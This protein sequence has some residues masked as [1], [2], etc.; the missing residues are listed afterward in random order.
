[1]SKSIRDKDI[2]LGMAV[3]VFIALVYISMILHT[4]VSIYTTAGHDDAWFI[5]SAEKILSA[6]WL[7][8]FSQITLMKG[9]GFSYFLVINNI[10]GFPV[11]L[12]IS[13]LYILACATL[14]YMLRKTGQGKLMGQV[15]F[16]VLLLQP[17]L[18]PMRII[19]D[20][21]YYSLTLMVISGM[22]YLAVTPSS[23]VKKKLLAF[24]GLTAGL[25]W[26]TREEGIWI[27]PGVI[28]I[29][30][31]GLLFTIKQ[32]SGM[33]AYTKHTVYYVLMALLIP[34]GT[35]V[36]NYF[37]YGAFEIVDFK[38]KSFVTAI[39][40][41]NS[42]KA[43]KE[44]PFVPVSYE[45]RIAIY[46]VSPAFRELKPYFEK[47]GKHWTEPGTRIY[48]HVHDDYASGWFMWALRDGVASRGYYKDPNS[49]RQYYS[50]LVKE[51]NQ[52]CLDGRLTCK[53]PLL[54]FMPNL[55]GNAIQSIP[56]KMVDA[57]KLTLYQ[58]DLPL[59]AGLSW[60]P[61]N[62]LTNVLNFLGN[63]RIIPP[64]RKV[65]VSG[66]YY[67]R[68]ESWISLVIVKPK[69]EEK[70]DLKRLRS[71]DIASSFK[72]PQA[73]HQ[74]YEFEVDNSDDIQV[75]L[76]CNNDNL[77]T[78]DEIELKPP[79]F[80]KVGNGLLHVDSVD[81]PD[82]RLEKHPAFV[83]KKAL[84][85]FFRYLS[86]ALFILGLI[87]LAVLTVITIKGKNGYPTLLAISLAFWSLY[88]SR[89]I[90]VVL[91][92]ITSF[93][94]INELYLLPAFPLWIVASFTSI[95]G[96]VNI[97]KKKHLQTYNAKEPKV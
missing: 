68:D 7:G 74:R 89:L 51:I 81:S 76:V 31:F 69:S 40:A 45:K 70:I 1:M 58:K 60:L 86:P 79:K 12:S 25:F 95:A 56:M 96:V 48:P 88:F 19:R 90:M 9:L 29:W 3:Y 39:N 17:A 16:F 15:L 53:K 28:I 77:I 18:V 35:G 71:P 94:A 4:P 46:K 10:L 52:A 2:A 37:N 75:N 83:I 44:I 13:L 20:D 34:I 50:R 62:R 33:Q 54:P 55:S 85:T 92:D 23:E 41:L 87:G 97:A 49:A 6:K 30:A 38:S 27:L 80:L 11:T 21:I 63:P 43:G 66:W 22:T 73:T 57:I 67:A 82:R 5:R 36:V 26:I 14:I 93:P 65:K 32:K 78:L 42:V 47:E 24:A 91:I 8:E 84:I 72:D 61:E 64:H 59:T